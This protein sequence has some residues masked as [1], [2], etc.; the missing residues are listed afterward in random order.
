MFSNGR[1]AWEGPGAACRRPRPAS[2]QG[3]SR[4]ETGIRGSRRSRTWAGS[5]SCSRSGGRKGLHGLW[6]WA[7]AAP[8]HYRF[9]VLH[10][11]TPAGE[12]LFPANC[13]NALTATGFSSSSRLAKSA[14]SLTGPTKHRHHHPGARSAPAPRVRIPQRQRVDERLPG[15]RDERDRVRPIGRAPARGLREHPR[16]S[17]C[18]PPGAPPSPRRWAAAALRRT[19]NSMQ[20]RPLW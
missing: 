1:T 6:A 3:R 4:T 12:L 11:F 15:A 18:Q 9:T 20:A 10:R 5:G 8:A 7:C 16:E 19:T 2:L 13:E 14:R 17:G